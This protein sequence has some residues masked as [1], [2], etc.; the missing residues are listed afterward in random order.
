MPLITLPYV[1]RVLG[2]ANYGQVSF[3]LAFISYFIL[4]TEYGF[5][6][7]GVR[8]ISVNHDNPENLNQ[9]F[10]S[11]IYT[12]IFL[13]ILSI[14]LMFGLIFGFQIF[15]KN[16]LLYVILSVYVLGSMINPIWFYQ[17]LEN[18]KA[19]PL[20]NL[21]PKAIAVVLIF[22]FVKNQG[23]I[24]IYAGIISVSHFIVGV[25]A[26]IYSFNI[27]NLKPIKVKFD[28]VYF[29]LKNS[30]KL[31]LSNIAISFYTSSNV[32]I[33]GL[34]TDETSVGIYSAADK[35]RLAIQGMFAPISQS[36]FPKVNYLITQSSKSFHSFNEKLIKI[37][38]TIAFAL[39]LIVF[40][41]AEQIV[42]IV[43]G[44]LYDSSAIVLRIIC[45]L[46]FVISISNVY[47]IQSLLVLKED[48]KF[49]K[50]VLSAALFSLIIVTSLTFLYKE[51]G[52]A[53]G[54]LLVEIYVSIFMFFLY[55][56]VLKE[57]EM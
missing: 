48:I 35:I 34:L 44:S 41:F 1:V 15:S 4:I 26:F 30:W 36:V 24:L 43:L 50:V 38:S 23:D 28:D 32:L 53:I 21:I 20:I 40:I 16:I 37:Q 47:G 2:P 6:L 5:N 46:P 8:D 55:K 25:F 56:K 29:Q 17:G 45:W 54:F 51:S 39:S 42:E 57:N 11:I 3:A 10:F 19:L 12:K 13:F 22:I 27:S 9:I 14:I 31:F 18:T 7:T 49:L 52:T 33:L